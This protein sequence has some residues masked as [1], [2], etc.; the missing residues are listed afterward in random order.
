[1]SKQKIRFGVNYVPRKNWWYCWGDWDIESIKEDL[2]AI[3]SI[4]M[5][6]I[7][8]F[9]IWPY[10][11]P[12][13]NY[14]SETALERL[15]EL[16]DTADLYNLDVQPAVLTGFLS[17][18]CFMP[19]WQNKRNMF[20]DPDMIIAEKQLFSSIAK[21]IGNHPRFMG[22]D[23]GNEINVLHHF[24]FGCD[25]DKSDEWQSEM[26]LHCNEISPGKFHVN[27]IG[28]EPWLMGSSY[29]PKCLANT[30][31]ATI[32]HPYI[33]FNGALDIYKPNDIGCLHFNEFLIEYVKAFNK[34]GDRLVWIQETGISSE[35][36]PEHDI[37]DFVEK[38]IRNAAACENLYGITWWSSH[39]L[40]RKYKGFMKFEYDLGLYDNNN[41]LK[42]IG[43]RVRDI[44]KE[45]KLE[46]PQAFQRPVAIVIP[47]D[48]YSQPQI[49]RP[50]N[51]EKHRPIWNVG[52]RYME[53]IAEGIRPGIIHEDNAADSEY[54]KGRGLKELVWI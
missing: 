53:L 32:L 3:S 27:G 46:Q 19:S 23:L 45:Y 48:L 30:G 9:P 40:D 42:P 50:R 17:G 38:S 29:S 51:Q 52:E 49:N 11:Q 12:N 39:E 25:I 41:H 54:L 26:L 34:T 2:H 4:G 13:E 20:T 14:V 33:F 22:F 36:I 21:K 35:W 37:P 44:I 7:R 8:V 24:N 31:A 43:K 16:M 1:M 15:I 5:D 18:F 6:H 28:G 10:F 47:K